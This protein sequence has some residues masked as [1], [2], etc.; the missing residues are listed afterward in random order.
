MVV[1]IAGSGRSGS[2]LLERTLGQMPGFVNVGELVD[3]FRRGASRGQRCSC[4]QPFGGCPFWASVVQDAFGDWADPRVAEVHPLQRRMARHGSLPLLLAMPLAGPRF[5]ADAARYGER[6][7][8]V[9]RAIAAAGGASCVVDA[10]KWPVQALALRRGGVDVRVIHLVRDARA[11]AHSHAKRA[12]K[13]PVTAARWVFHQAEAETLRLG[14]VPVARVRYEDFVRWPR[15]TLQDALARLGLPSGPAQFGHLTGGQ[16]VLG[17]SHGVHG[18]P[19]RFRQGRI[20]LRN[21]EAWREGMPRRERLV[22]TAIG[23]P[24]LLRYGWRPGRP[25][26]RPPVPGA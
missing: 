4:G 13:P 17:P 25:P 10:S 8:A 26:G 6:Y 3:L 24:L 14:G 7:G 21:D 1:Y 5:R 23:L 12:R 18:N 22:V 16:V 11:V 2:T 19:G 9:Y 20:A 15:Q